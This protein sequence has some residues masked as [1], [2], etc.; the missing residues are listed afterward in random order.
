MVSYPTESEL[1][2]QHGLYFS[3]QT[4][5]GQELDRC[6]DHLSMGFHRVRTEEMSL[7]AGH[8]PM[9]E[10]QEEGMNAINLPLSPIPFELDP[11]DTMLEENEVRT[12]VDPNSRSDPKLQELM[13]VL[14]DWINDVLVG[15]RIIVKD[16]AEDLYD[17][18][19]LQKLFGRRVERCSGCGF[20]GRCWITYF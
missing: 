3:D 4:A 12:M 6:P 10:L 11:E 16:L 13:K 14:I 9:S 20:N 18:Q 19:V 7:F 8:W 17:G 2:S 1:P 15:E 5:S